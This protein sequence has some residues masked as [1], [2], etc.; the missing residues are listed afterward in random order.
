MKTT[1]YVLP[2]ALKTNTTNSLDISKIRFSDTSY[3]KICPEA[4]IEFKKDTF[5]HFIDMYYKN[6]S[7]V[8]QLP[9][10]TIESINN[11]KMII[12]IDDD[13]IKYLIK[14]LEEHIIN[15]VHNQSEKWFNG[16]RFTMNKIMNSIVS[17]LNKKDGKNTLKVT[18][19]KHTL[20]FNRYKNMMNKEDIQ[21]SS[22]DIEIVCLVKISNLQFLQNK[23]S[24]NIVLEQAKVFMEERLIEYSI[25]DDP[26]G[27]ISDSISVNNSCDGEY[28]HESIDSENHEFF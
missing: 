16:K 17:P 4:T 21:D 9:K 6:Q 11:N 18:L 26:D 24:Y 28:Y 2:D 23:F 27:K 19:D 3:K 25:I 7:L 15:T 12:Y 10:Y 8:L 5:T 1:V 14:P 20:Y 13:L 22:S